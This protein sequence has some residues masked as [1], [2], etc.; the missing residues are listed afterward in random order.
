VL[1]HSRERI[2]NELDDDLARFAERKLATRGVEIILND[3]VK[4]A[5]AEGI[6]LET[7]RLV[8]TATVICTVGNS[9]HPLL[10]KSNL[11][12]EKGRLLVDEYLRV[13]GSDHLWS[14]GD[15]AMVPDVRRGGTCP[16]TAQYAMRQGRCAAKNILAVI[17]GAAPKPFVFGGLGQLAVVGRHSGVA[18][19]MGIK[20]AGLLAWWLWR[21]VYWMKLPGL[22]CKIRVGIDWALDVLFPRDITKFAVERTE[23]LR[24]AHY[25]KGD[26]IFKQGEIGDRFFIIESGQVEVLHEQEGQPPKQLATRG[27]GESF[28]EFAILKRQPRMATVRCLTPVDVVTFTRRDFQ[29][30]V[31]SYPAFRRK[32]EQDIHG[33]VGDLPHELSETIKKM[34]TEVG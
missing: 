28:G 7:G 17:Q 22:R 32:L 24:R 31:G 16:P 3:R 30:L 9:P 6:V 15:S 13:H 5:T 23:Q 25:R 1:V 14:L 10:A 26:I 2:L 21:S 12:Q 19:V 29:T 33:W 8:P 18:Q 34:G 4:E 27:A 20:F 11:P